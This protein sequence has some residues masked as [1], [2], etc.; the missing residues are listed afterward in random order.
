MAAAKDTRERELLDVLRDQLAAKL[1]IAGYVYDT[2]PKLSPGGVGGE[3]VATKLKK[4]SEPRGFLG[5][6]MLAAVHMCP[7][8]PP[9][10]ERPEFVEP[11]CYAVPLTQFGTDLR[12]ALLNPLL[13]DGFQVGGRPLAFFHSRFASAL[14]G[15]SR[16]LCGARR[17]SSVMLLILIWPSSSASSLGKMHS[18]SLAPIL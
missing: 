17:R 12:K 9:D 10:A 13:T 7:T 5:Q 2:V 3:N 11:M 4:L 1:F 14:C 8:P 18:Q 16:L 15:N 6:R